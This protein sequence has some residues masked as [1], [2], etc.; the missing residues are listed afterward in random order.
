MAGEKEQVDAYLN[1]ISR[2]E[3]NIAMIDTGAGVASIAISLK[4]IADSLSYLENMAR[5]ENELIQKARR[6]TDAR[7]GL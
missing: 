2:L 1:T 5:E 3:P 7:N 6:A 4:R